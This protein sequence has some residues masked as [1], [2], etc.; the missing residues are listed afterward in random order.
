MRVAHTFNTDPF[1]I[2][3]SVVTMGEILD[4]IMIEILMVQNAIVQ[5]DV[6]V[7]KAECVSVQVNLD[8]ACA[9]QIVIVENNL[10]F[11]FS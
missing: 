7:T 9:D 2:T 6:H 3:Y 10:L 1:A 4:L 5:K 8:L 11:V